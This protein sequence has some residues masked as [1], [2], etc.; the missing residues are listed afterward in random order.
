MNRLAMKFLILG[1]LC[2][3]APQACTAAHGTS[4]AHPPQPII[5]MTPGSWRQ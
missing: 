1:P 5:T 4:M 2:V 3:L